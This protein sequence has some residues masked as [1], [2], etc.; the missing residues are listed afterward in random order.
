MANYKEKYETIIAKLKEAKNDSDLREYKFGDIIEGLVPE[1]AESD[2]EKIRK[3]IINIIK[4]ARYQ[5][6][7]TKYIDWIERHKEWSNEDLKM[8]S[9]IIDDA[10]K[11]MALLPK[12]IEWLKSIKPQPE[13]KWDIAELIKKPISSWKPTKAHLEAIRIASTIGVSEDSWA[14]NKFKEMYKELKNLK[15]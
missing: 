11:P 9:S 5:N 7:D 10:Q 1:L 2:D 12:Q 3:E 15:L 4:I 14:M 13:Q 8:L 6:D